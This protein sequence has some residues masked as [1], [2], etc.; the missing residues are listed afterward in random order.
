MKIKIFLIIFITCYFA[1]TKEIDISAYFENNY[2]S[3]KGIYA[4]I[5]V[6]ASITLT[7]QVLQ[8]SPKLY[9]AVLLQQTGKDIHPL[10][11][12]RSDTPVMFAELSPAQ[13]TKDFSR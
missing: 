3:A 2:K 9:A 8:S 13:K 12:A 6:D 7:P 1:D 11:D 10:L 4:F 5:P